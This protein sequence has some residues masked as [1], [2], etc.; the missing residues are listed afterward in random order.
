MF[1]NKFVITL[2]VFALIVLGLWRGLKINS[3]VIESPL[4]GKRV[5][6]FYLPSVY[7]KHAL[8]SRK[9]FQGRVTL[10]NVFATWCYACRIEHS[11]L[12]R[13]SK[14]NHIRIIG[15]DYHD[16]RENA[17]QWIQQNGNPYETIIFDPQGRLAINLG[18]YGTPETF[19]IDRK[20]IIRY[21]YTGSINMVAWKRDLY[22]IIK[23]L[24]DA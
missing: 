6:I 11:M 13:L 2:V 16:V 3:H 12:M 5:P 14:Q 20:G 17:L 21:K 7:D 24:N 8:L 9:I 19:I 18:V 23:K 1:K 15:L 10:L 22:P 4:I